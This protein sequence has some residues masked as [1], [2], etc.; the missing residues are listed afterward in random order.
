MISSKDRKCR[1]KF[2]AGSVYKNVFLRL[3]SLEPVIDSRYDAVGNI[4]EIFPQDVPFK[5]SG[6]IELQY[7]VSDTQP[8]QLG[9]YRKS[10]QGWGFVGNKIDF[11]RRVI[12]SQ[13]ANLGVF[14]LIQ[15]T[16]T[17]VLTVRY[18][19]N[20]SVIRD[21]MPGLLAVVYDDLSGIEDER[22]IVMKLDGQIVIAEYDPE[23]RTIKYIPEAPLSPDEHTISVWAKDNS[24][25]EIFVSNKFTIIN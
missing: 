3:E 15:D 17:P 12:S 5:K 20:N 23:A 25:N 7:P 9:I 18:P 2:G 11:E 22:S 19:Q 13:V 16:I 14:T 24:N 1:I 10:R 21:D 4:Y 8:E 6:R